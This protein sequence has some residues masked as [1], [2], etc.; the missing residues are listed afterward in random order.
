MFIFQQSRPGKSQEVQQLLPDIILSSADKFLEVNKHY[1]VAFCRN[2]NLE[3]GSK[4]LNEKDKGIQKA[5]ALALCAYYLVQY[6][7]IAEINFKTVKQRSEELEE[8]DK[9]RDPEA[10]MKDLVFPK[11]NFKGFRTYAD[12]D[13]FC[14]LYASLLK[15]VQSKANV[16]FDAHV[17]LTSSNHGQDHAQVELLLGGQ[18]VIADITGFLVGPVAKDK[19]DFSHEDLV[20][21]YKSADPEPEKYMARINEIAS[22]PFPTFKVPKE[23]AEQ[24]K[25]DLSLPIAILS[26]KRMEFRARLYN[27]KN[28]DVNMFA[29]NLI[30]QGQNA[31]IADSIMHIMLN[32][33][34][35]SKEN[36]SFFESSNAFEGLDT[37]QKIELCQFCLQTFNV[38]NAKDPKAFLEDAR[39]KYL[40]IDGKWSKISSG[41]LGMSDALDIFPNYFRFSFSDD[42][43]PK[44]VLSEIIFLKYLETNYKHGYVS[45]QEVLDFAK[46]AE[47]AGA[48]KKWNYVTS[49]LMQVLPEVQNPFEL[50]A[51]M[52]KLP[53]VADSAELKKEIDQIVMAAKSKVPENPFRKSSHN[54]E[55]Y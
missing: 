8:S 14:T 33:I 55:F 39:E 54:N 51:I 27:V 18:R 26:F 23:L 5:W 43:E 46:M 6:G 34:T 53:N 21:I 19:R 29:S 22:K 25:N 31:A 45:A 12:C 20:Q 9:F 38:K 49:F 4:K 11:E 15:S 2:Y 44:K 52:K 32:L 41:G 16:D 36:N 24:W 47:H 42:F 7:G 10:I 40:E 48:L 1:F 3:M 35:H 13:E 50:G 17:V 37:R 30:K 28:M